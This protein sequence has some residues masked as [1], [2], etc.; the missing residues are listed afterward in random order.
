[1]LT[2]IHW[3]S[4]KAHL[5]VSQYAA[6][7]PIGTVAVAIGTRGV[8]SSTVTTSSTTEGVATGALV[9]FFLPPVMKGSGITPH[10]P[11]HRQQRQYMSSQ[12]HHGRPNDISVV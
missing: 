10:M 5:S 11:K 12:N 8:S 6:G 4:S 1:M 7:Y 3:E 9:G 2:K